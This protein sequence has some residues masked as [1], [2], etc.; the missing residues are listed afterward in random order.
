METLFI[1][2][3]KVIRSLLLITVMF[4]IRTTLD[5]QMPA[6]ITIDPP[7]ASGN[8]ELT[9]TFDPAL[10]CFQT[11]SLAGLPSIAIHSAVTLSDGITWQHIVCFNCTGANGQSPTLLP[12]G[13]GRYAINYKPSEFY[14]IAPGEI[15]TQICAVF[16][17]GFDWS[18]DGRDFIQG[19][20]DCMDFYIPLNYQ[21]DEPEL[22]FRLNMNKI[23][24]EGNFD[25]SSDEVYIEMEEA[26]TTLLGDEDGDGIYEVD[27]TE[28]LAVDTAYTYIFRINDDL[29]EDIPRTVTAIYG[30]LTV[31]LWWNDDPMPMVTFVIDMIYQFMMGNFTETDFVDV[32]GTMN[33]WEGSGPMEHI[34]YFLYS[35]TLPADP[36]IVEYIFRINGNWTTAEYLGPEVN[37]M[38][39]ATPE[40]VSVYHYYNDYNWETWPV[41]FEVDMNAEIEAG[42]FNPSTDFLDIAGTMNG[43]VSHDCLFDRAWTGDGIYT[44]K[45]L[46]D[47][48][49]PYIEFKFRINGD[50]ATSE[51]PANGPNRSFTAT[52]TTGGSVNLYS[53]VYNITDVPYPPYAYEM[54]ISGDLLI[55]EEVTGIYTYF[56]PNADP[57][58][59]SLYQ[60][61]RATEPHGWDAVMIQGAVFQNY[62]L[63]EEDYGKFMVFEVTPVAATGQPLMGLPLST[64]SDLVGAVLINEY[65]REDFQIYPNPAKNFLEISGNFRLER[66]KIQDF[67]GRNILSRSCDNESSLI[68]PLTELKKGIYFIT[69]TGPC[70]ECKVKKF[71]KL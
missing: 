47:I 12:T 42:N 29:Y 55:G 30:S 26:D 15:I 36:G 3:K 41:T 67:A 64:V 52:D 65:S 35:V 22:H 1:S 58:G 16:N 44:V 17:N 69:L 37:R 54:S 8:D 68:I 13:D 34:G 19:T 14:G 62:N 27:I 61:Y 11:G 71:I 38:T 5:A 21:G 23:I 25:P 6:A 70:G 31:D 53:C 28:G 56:D 4:L 40:P 7:N 18:Q 57:E 60:W 32:A 45:M 59:I 49:N 24:S 48:V 50:W 10:A 63:T 66:F 43:W 33:N 2:I 9:L 46:I 51:F 39:W 20:S